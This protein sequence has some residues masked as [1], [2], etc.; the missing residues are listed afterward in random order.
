[1]ERQEP[2]EDIE[3]TNKLSEYV[4]HIGENI[5][6]IGVSYLLLPIVLITCAIFPALLWAA[7]GGECVANDGR[8][9]IGPTAM[10]LFAGLDIIV[11]IPS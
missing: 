9:E 5:K 6:L 2:H 8:W 11:S 4:K 1:M 10:Q 7:L 3:C